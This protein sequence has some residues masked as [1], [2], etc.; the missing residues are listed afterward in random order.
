MNIINHCKYRSLYG[1]IS[2]IYNKG[3][4]D[5][6]DANGDTGLMWACR[7]GHDDIVAEMLR[8]QAKTDIKNNRG[9]TALTI[10][11]YERYNKIVRLLSEVS[12][13]Y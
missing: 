3:F 6:R 1:V 13:I 12:H 5:R 7:K 8:G 11:K 2:F 4:I 9:E 10:A